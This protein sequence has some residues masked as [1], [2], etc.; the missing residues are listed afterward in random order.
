LLLNPNRKG[1]VYE[2]DLEYGKVVQE[3]NAGD[4]VPDIRTLGQKNKYAERTG[5]AVVLGVNN[6]T[7]FS[8]DPRQHGANKLA[9]HKSY[10]TNNKFSTLAT[11]SSGD[12]AVGADDGQ[13][14]LY[15]SI[16]KVAKSCLP[17]LGDAIVGM[18]VTADGQFVLATTAHYLLVI[19][20]AVE[21]QA[22][23]GFAQSITAKASAPI[24]LAL[25]PSD[26]VQYGIKELNFTPAKFNTGDKQEQFI[27]TS[28]GPYIIT[29]SETEQQHTNTR[30][31]V[32][33]DC[34]ERDQGGWPSCVDMLLLP[35][36][37]FLAHCRSPS[38]CALFFLRSCRNFTKIKA[39]Q[40]SR[41]AFLSFGHYS[42]T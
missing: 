17:G 31:H 30:A 5:E 13:I 38:L 7:V 42:R 26:M 37:W 32:C 29:W 11:T 34:G 27:S 24:K 9:E 40:S 14:R 4:A 15:N 6:N 22:K 36:A 18:D 10:K 16:S 8:L 25:D 33:A 1:Q 35:L 28:T 12:V 39:G 21:G 19:P 3:Y 41:C 23:S 20:T 2:M